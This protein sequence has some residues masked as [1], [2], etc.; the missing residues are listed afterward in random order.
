MNPNL[1]RRRILLLFIP[2][3]SSL[4]LFFSGCSHPK[5]ALPPAPLYTITLGSKQL[6]VEVALDEPH[7]NR[8]LM[9][10][11]KLGP[12]EGMLFAYPNE[13]T[14]YFWM[15]ETYVPLSVA[16]IRADGWIIQIEDMEPLDLV[17]H[18]SRM[19]GRY[20]LEMPK[21]WFARNGIKEGDT[22]KI[23]EEIAK[24]AVE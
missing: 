4:I 20:A 9:H 24:A 21:G 23:P 2:H 3:L 6:T 5:D 12:D 22:V 14:L 1:G 11:K 7:R 19:K 8:G 16:F 18:R 13:D 15:K 17:S 10:R